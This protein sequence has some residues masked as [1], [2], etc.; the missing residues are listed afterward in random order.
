MIHHLGPG[1]ALPTWLE[2]LEK[3]AFDTSWGPLD[4]QEQLWMLDDLAYARWSLIPTIGEAE[5]L[6]IA[7]APQAR[8]KGLGRR[9]LRESIQALHNLGVTQFHLEVRL[10]NTPA[11]H[12]YESEGW[13]F[14]GIRKGY[15]RDGEDAALYALGDSHTNLHSKK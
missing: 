1:S 14:Q 9:L 4:G 6:R 12:L 11:R 2:A 15:Y 10:S 7:V 13:Q 8:G 3:T 5:L